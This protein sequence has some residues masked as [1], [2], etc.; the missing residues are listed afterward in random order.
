[1]VGSNAKCSR[2]SWPLR[3]E[4]LRFTMCLSSPG[5]YTWNCH[6][7]EK[8]TLYVSSAIMLQLEVFT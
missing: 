1:V 5:T 7:Q 2:M 3:R 6:G 4:Q 8:G